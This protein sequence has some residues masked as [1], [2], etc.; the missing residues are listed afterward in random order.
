LPKDFY[1]L[2]VKEKSNCKFTYTWRQLKV[3]IAASK[4]NTLAGT[5]S[6]AIYIATSIQPQNGFYC[7]RIDGLYNSGR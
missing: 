7:G 1:Q 2:Q 3:S 4:L 6:I 5:V